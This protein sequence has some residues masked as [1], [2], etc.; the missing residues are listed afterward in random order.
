MVSTEVVTG[1]RM[2]GEVLEEW[3]NDTAE[4]FSEKRRRQAAVWFYQG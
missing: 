2:S 1:S 3:E 4:F